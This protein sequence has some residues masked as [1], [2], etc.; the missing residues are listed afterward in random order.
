MLTKKKNKME[1]Y[2]IVDFGAV[3]DGKTLNTQAIQKAI[4]TCSEKGGGS[5]VC[6]GGN[7]IT[8]TLFLKSNVNLQIQQGTT[9]VGSQNLA[10]YKDLVD[11][12]FVPVDGTIE[13]SKNA[14]ILASFA[15]NISITGKGEINGSG[16]A[17]YDHKTADQ[18]GKFAK[19]DN[20]RPRIMMLYRCKNVLIEDIS[21]VDSS[22]WTIWLM[23]CENVFIHRI[24]IS[25][26]RRMRNVD[27]IDIDGCKN[28]VISDCIIDTED[29]CIAVR[30]IKDLY[31]Q[32]TVC[33]NLS[34]SN[35]ILK[36]GCNAIRI[37]CPADGEIK[38]CVFSNIVISESTNGILFE[39]PE[40]YLTEGKQASADVHDIMFNN[41]LIN[42]RRS[43]IKLIIEEGIRI[44]NLSDIFFSN[45]RIA[46]N[47]SPVMVCGS[48]Q[49]IIQNIRFD[50]IEII[51]KGEQ[52]ILCK[53]CTSVKINNVE[54]SNNSD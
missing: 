25:G 43:A 32:P 8:G 23:Q 36:T 6:S 7:F 45:I 54:I 34:V 31:Q 9:I 44:K 17:F 38:N 14:L 33:E 42:S 16:L 18:S 24:K 48:S 13:K 10:H 21:L 15:E 49:S 51:T 30:S 29:D 3:P 1:I 28:V 40:R 11:S 26:D 47:E 19:P 53:H 12:G 52:A 41:F 37:G 39:Y 27:G 5:V 35:C 50:N 22:C 4:D 20:Q 2:N 46:K